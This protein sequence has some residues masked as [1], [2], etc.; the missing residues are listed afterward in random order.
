MITRSLGIL[1]FSLNLSAVQSNQQST[2]GNTGIVYGSHHAFML[3]APEGW[4]LDNSSGVSQGVYAVFYPKGGSWEKS[5]VV[6]YA[7]T[8]SRQE[9]GNET[10]QKVIAFDTQKFRSE[11]PDIVVGDLPSLATKDHKS[12]IVKTFFYSQYEAVAYIEEETIVSMLVIT[13]RTKQQFEQSRSAFEQLVASYQFL[14]TDV[15]SD[16]N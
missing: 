13:A 6:M 11:H 9:E 14:T 10:V 8:T 1:L 5:P 12:A 3:S 4:V 7:N 16:Q 15:R 2:G